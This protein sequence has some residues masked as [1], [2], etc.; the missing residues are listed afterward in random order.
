MR[1]LLIPLAFALGVTITMLTRSSGAGVNRL[2]TRIPPSTPADWHPR[3]REW[4]NG[5][6]VVGVEVSYPHG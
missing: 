5:K 1:Y 6:E 2:M 3:Y 4:H